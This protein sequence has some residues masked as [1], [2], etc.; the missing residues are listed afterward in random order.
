[1]TLEK[2]Y[3]IL[4]GDFA[5]VCRRLPGPR[6]VERFLERYLTDN[7]AKCLVAALDSE[8]AAESYRFALA[9]KGVAGNL[10]FGE[11]EETVAQLTVLLRAGK[12]TPETKRMGQTVWRQH[13]AAVKT[14]RQYIA[15]K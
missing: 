7:S 14:I 8:D 2:L 11:L 12:V 6:F 13:L 9:L 1:M 3:Q 15:E 5:D 10:G 4:G